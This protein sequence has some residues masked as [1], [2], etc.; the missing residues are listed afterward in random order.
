MLLWL[1]EEE[2]L[3]ECHY[4][5]GTEVASP[6][7]CSHLRPFILIDVLRLD[8]D[9]AWGVCGL[10]HRLICE[11]RLTGGKAHLSQELLIGVHFLPGPYLR[12]MRQA[13]AQVCS[14][15]RAILADSSD[16]LKPPS[17]TQRSAVHPARHGGNGRRQ[18]LGWVST[19]CDGAARLFRRQEWHHLG[20]CGMQRS[21][22]L[23]SGVFFLRLWLWKI[24][25]LKSRHFQIALQFIVITH[26][27]TTDSTL[28]ITDHYAKQFHISIN[29]STNHEA[30][31]KK[32]PNW[33]KVVHSLQ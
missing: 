15:A 6:V 14:K 23:V 31:V 17:R 10:T 28:H 32:F 11:N 21:L 27:N 30:T 29:I 3:C 33:Y 25:G 2:L 20:L 9:E 18:R 22:R 8:R 7:Q 24:R 13:G 26:L 1:T 4:L 19:S 12:E 16:R 5:W